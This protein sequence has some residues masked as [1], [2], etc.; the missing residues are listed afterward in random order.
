MVCN[1]GVSLTPV[2]DGQLHHFHFAGVYD[3][4]FVMTDE[5]T[6]SLWNHVTGEAMHGPLTGTQLARSNLLP[7]NVTVALDMDSHIEV[8]I[9][10]RPL[11][12]PDY[13]TQE[14]LDA[15]VPQA[16]VPTMGT[17]DQRRP[18][19][20]LGV[21]IWTDQAHRY[22][23]MEAIAARG[24]ALIDNFE[25]RPVLIYIEPETLTP[26]AV[27]VDAQSVTWSQDEVRLDTGLVVKP[28][29]FVAPDGVP[30]NVPQPLK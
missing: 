1:S 11:D 19:M 23:P 13:L 30:S 27:F 5:E 12:L 29:F 8:A 9:S 22:Y 2:V 21:G 15:G 3:G 6:G 17:E 26:A 10:D 4:L 16:F 25:G 24:N 28:G 20:D 18:R 14:G 7:M